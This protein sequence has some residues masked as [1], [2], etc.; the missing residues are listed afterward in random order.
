[1]GI[2]Q[3]KSQWIILWDST[4]WFYSSFEKAQDPKC[5]CPVAK[6]CLILWDLMNCSTPGF[7]L[8]HYLLEFAQTHVHQVNN[9][10]QTS[11]PLLPRPLSSCP[12]TIPETGS[13]SMSQLFTSGGQNIRASVSASVLPMNIQGWF[14][15]LTG[16]ISSLSTVFQEYFSTTV[17]KYQFFSS[18]P[19]L[20]FNS[21]R[22]TIALAI[23]T[24]FDNVTSRLFI[25]LPRFFI[26]FLP[27]SKHLLISYLQSF[28]KARDPE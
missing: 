19:S 20:R 7:P 16:L 27:R 24:F 10:I 13:F 8:L 12:Q 22:K 15:G 23:Q 21:P 6:S 25:M 17:Q 5:C 4:N 11:H 28:E 2:T 18:Q 26:A 3:P 14:P 9:A 1:M